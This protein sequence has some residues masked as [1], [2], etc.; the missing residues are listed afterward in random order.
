MNVPSYD[1]YDEVVHDP[2]YVKA[3]WH[4]RGSAGNVPVLILAFSL[5]ATRAFCLLHISKLTS[6]NY[7]A[8]WLSTSQLTISPLAITA[9]AEDRS[10]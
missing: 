9:L 6:G 7:G 10:N 1:P 4:T 3:I 8:V 2:Q 5:G